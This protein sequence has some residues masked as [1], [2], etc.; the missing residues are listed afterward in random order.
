MRRSGSSFNIGHLLDLL[1]R[2]DVVRAVGRTVAT[3]DADLGFVLF[4]IPENG[5]E[6]TGLDAVAA[7]DAEVSLEVDPAAIARGE[8]VGGTNAGT[9][10]V[11]TGSADHDDE[12][13]PHPAR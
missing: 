1:Q 6:R 8:S 10:W 9:G 11:G 3:V 5:P 7:T 2:Q 13:P 4:R 12:S